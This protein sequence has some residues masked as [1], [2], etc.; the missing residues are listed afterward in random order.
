MITRISTA[1]LLLLLQTINKFFISNE[2][3][4]AS[5]FS[6]FQRQ[7]QLYCPHGHWNLQGA[8]WFV[9]SKCLSLSSHGVV[10]KVLPRRNHLSNKDAS[11]GCKSSSLTMKTFTYTFLQVQFEKYLTTAC[12]NNTLPGHIPSVS[13][14][15]F[16]R[17]A[18]RPWLWQ[19]L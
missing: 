4:T 3:N 10:H 15:I 14:K 16:S 12:W 1:I 9:G 5:S 11:E 13:I 18:Q 19:A 2:V 8:P 17:S 7:K 6:S